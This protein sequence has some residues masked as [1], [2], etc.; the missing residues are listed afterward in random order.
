M[1]TFGA[2]SVNHFLSWWLQFAFSAMP[3]SSQSSHLKVSAS[4]AT[5]YPSDY[6]Q[7]KL[8]TLSHTYYIFRVFSSKMSLFMSSGFL[9]S[10]H[11]VDWEKFFVLN[12]FERY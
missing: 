7:M 2:Q 4:S 10:Y 6:C 5:F 9:N 1:C 8:V 12:V 11:T 3:L